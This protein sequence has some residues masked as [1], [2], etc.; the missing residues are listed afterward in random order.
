[1][2]PKEEERLQRKEMDRLEVLGLQQAITRELVNHTSLADPTLA[3]FLIHLHSQPHVTDVE[4]FKQA[5]KG[6]GAEFPDSFIASVDR[7]ILSMH[8][9]YKKKVKKPKKGDVAA[10]GEAAATEQVI[11][12]DRKRQM[13]LFPGLAMPDQDWQPSYAI[14]PKDAAA[15][16]KQADVD[17]GVDDLM[18]QLE[19]VKKRVLDESGAGGEEREQKR[20]RDD[21][22]PD[23]GRGG[24]GGREDDRGRPGYGRPAPKRQDDKP[25]L[26]KVYPGK[27]SSM[28][29]FGAFVSV[30]GVAGRVEGM[31]SVSH[32]TKS[33]KT[34]AP[35][36][37]VWSTSAPLE[38]D[39]SPT[40]RTFSL[41]AS[42]SSSRSCPSPAAAS[43]SR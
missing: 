10:K 20:S 41:A 7:L 12:E 11:D 25:V 5:C 16:G 29:P 13:R 3:E 40:P 31:H 42:P 37:Q 38:R 30:E 2:S 26:Y 23:R 9:K 22:S 8:P 34:D 33:A 43:G 36:F 6:V 32:V 19:G 4:S 27:V 35:L 17:L 14:D 24:Y 18:S 28:K 15:K 39:A 1:M 21:K